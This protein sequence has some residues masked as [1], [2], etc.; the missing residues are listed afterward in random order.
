L[1]GKGDDKEEVLRYLHPFSLAPYANW[2]DFKGY[3]WRMHRSFANGAIAGVR[4]RSIR[5][6]RVAKRYYFI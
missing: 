6:P 5:I 2:K 3:R 1:I 4:Y